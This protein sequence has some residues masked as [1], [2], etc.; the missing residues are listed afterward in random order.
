MEKA[1]NGGTRVIQ[2]MGKSFEFQENLELDQ[3]EK[4][5]MQFMQEDNIVYSYNS[6]RE[7]LF[8]IKVR[9]NIINSARAMNEA[10]PE[11]T[12]FEQARCNPNY[13]K[14]TKAGGF[15]LRPDVRPSDAIM[16]I[17][18]NSS[19]YAFECATASVIIYYYATL[20][21][22]GHHIFNTYFQGL[23]LY[24]WHTDT[25]LGLVTFHS[26][27]FLP[28]DIVYFDNPDFNP[29][30]PWFRGVNA[31]LLDDSSFFGHGF[32]IKTNE[33]IV[34]VLN[35]QRRQG[36]N[37]SAALTSLLTRP[38]FSRLSALTNRQ[39]TSIDFKIKQPFVHHNLSSISLLN[40]NNYLISLGFQFF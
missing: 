21:T 18:K 10:R 20:Q 32:S 37:R 31:I 17:F 26:S 25:D 16:D 35:K 34:Q 28:G 15:L 3:V 24:S 7:L 5:I 14:L 8:E 9:K 1:E 19:L 30:T 13:W 22:L 40:Y 23:Y 12:I 36:S 4:N 27:G 38:S 11:F 39:P 33:K 6:S 29:Q 2:V